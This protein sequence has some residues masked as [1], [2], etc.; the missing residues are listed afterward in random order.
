M[1]DLEIRL[2]KK[3]EFD[4][5][6]NLMN[7]AFSFVN[8]EEKFE[9]ILPKLYFKENKDMIHYGAFVDG[10]L[11]A[12]IG[13]Y[14]MTF[15]SKYSSLKVGCVGAVSTHPEYRKN[16][17]F[18]LIMKKIISY[19]KSHNFDMLFLSG[20]RFRYNHFGFENA[21]RK[22]LIG[23][24]Q[25]TKHVLKGEK[26]E[27]IKL[28]RNNVDDIKDCLS[29]YSKQP[30]HILR[31]RDNFFNHVISWN[32]EPYVVKVAG[33]IIGYYSIKDNNHICECVFKKKYLDT[34]L[35]ACLADR[36]EVYIELPFSLY[37]NE[38]ITKVDMYE[39]Q[40][41][42]MYNV[43]NWENVK[44]YLDF[45]DSKTVEFGKMSKKDKFR[46]LLGCDEFPA[47]FSK[48]NMFVYNCDQG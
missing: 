13:L 12:S 32:C 1:S 43:L 44:T 47:K 45:D 23:V 36:N 31:T 42:L 14:F 40:Y 46:A 24:S 39:V 33:E 3:N 4:D 34:M 8:K 29:L 19:S 10:V 41:N 21:G 11:V 30:Q 18:S 35:K 25:R 7:T 26:F 22:L 17:Y 48:L 27:I 5:L 37:S 16:G 28:D 38:L 15:K 20:N 2:V 9:H 6:M